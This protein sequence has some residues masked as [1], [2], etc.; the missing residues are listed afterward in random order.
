MLFDEDSASD[1]CSLYYLRNVLN[2]RNVK[3]DPKDDVNG[4][5]DFLEVIIDSLIIHAVSVEFGSKD[6]KTLPQPMIDSIDNLKSDEEKREYLMKVSLNIVDKYMLP[7]SPGSALST[8]NDSQPDFVNNYGRN[9]LTLGMMHR[10]FRDSVREGDGNRVILAWKM[11]LPLFKQD[12]RHK[13][14]LEAFMLLAQ[15]AALLSPRMAY[16][17]RWGRFVNTK[18]GTGHNV[19][20]DHHLEHMNKFLKQALSSVAPSFKQEGAHAI[21]RIANAISKCESIMS[22][23]D[24]NFNI[25][26]QRGSQHSSKTMR[27]DMEEVLKKLYSKGVFRFEE[28]RKY[29]SSKCNRPNT[30]FDKFDMTKFQKWVSKHKEKYTPK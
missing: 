9:L 6:G 30:L 16:Q 7:L 22:Q 8:T 3:K 2:R 29:Y 28:G 21:E 10:Y 27:S 18:G 20:G 1:L 19:S 26:H 13:Y 4:A 14:A 15:D 17:L 12:G 5:E 23:F 25:H 11:F 24:D